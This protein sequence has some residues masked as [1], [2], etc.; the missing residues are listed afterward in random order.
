MEIRNC[1]KG[2]DK[3]VCTKKTNDDKKIE[4]PAT[5]TKT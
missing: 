4:H 3:I 5:L 2:D 1:E